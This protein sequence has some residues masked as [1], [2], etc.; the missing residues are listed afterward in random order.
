MRVGPREKPARIRPSSVLAATALALGSALLCAASLSAA[1]VDNPPAE[2]PP[3]DPHFYRCEVQPVF[4]QGCAALACHGDPARPFHVFTRGRERL[5]GD[6]LHR[7][8]PTSAE[9]LDAGY[10][11]ARAFALAHEATPEATWLLLKPLEALL[12]VCTKIGNRYTLIFNHIYKYNN[13]FLYIQLTTA[14]APSLPSPLT[15]P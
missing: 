3:L 6:N 5:E 4:D 12:G 9:E 13:K 11:S 10:Q 1:C 8:L 7:D 15:K 14:S 2:G